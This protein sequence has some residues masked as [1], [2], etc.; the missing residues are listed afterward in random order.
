MKL[1]VSQKVPAAWNQARMIEI[2][3]AIETQSN[4]HAEGRLQGRHLSSASVP[5]T[6]NFGKGDIV[7]DSNPTLSNG[8][9]RIGWICTVA[10]APGTFQ[11]ILVQAASY[12]PILSSVTN[13]LGAD[14]SLNDT[15]Q[16]FTGPSV[17]QGSS[18]TWFASG[19][20][21]VTDGAGAAAFNAKLW[22]GT[23]VI[24]SAR[25]STTAGNQRA[26]MSLSGRLATPAGNIRIS[27]NDET[28]TSGTIIFN[29]SGNSMD[30][31]LTAMRIG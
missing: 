1:S 11:E 8:T 31:T 7:W 22:D 17:S 4:L 28:S 15:G 12:V 26:S 16:Y 21:T 2:I 9:V 6:G 30:S 27:V 25:V 20:V 5:T 29:G 18:G 14:V 13:S 19:T 23:S 10:G 3:G 24:A